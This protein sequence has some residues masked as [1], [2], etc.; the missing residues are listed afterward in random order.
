MVGLAGGV[1]TDAK[2]RTG[3]IASNYQFQFD[4]P[5]QAGAIYT[6]GFS[7]CGNNSV[8]LG[9]STVFYECASGD[10][11]N[12]YDRNWAPQCSAV[13]IVAM[14]CGGPDPPFASQIPDGQVI[15]TT[16]VATTVVVPLSDGQ[17]QVVTT[18][19]PV[20]ICQ[21]G[22]GKHFVPP[23]PPNIRLALLLS[24]PRETLRPS[25]VLPYP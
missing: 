10:F 20:P 21:I 12:L 3:Y 17:P 18:Q 25:L 15:G 23:F 2:A 1:L 9:G 24:S 7:V 16:V 4:G 19:V 11:Y 6:A 8:A 22:D 5:P 13:E 14:P